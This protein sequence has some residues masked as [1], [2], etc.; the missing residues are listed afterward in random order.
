MAG[1]DRGAI[2]KRGKPA[3]APMMRPSNTPPADMRQPA[4]R[5]SPATSSA[6]KDFN[7]I[8][9]ARHP[10]ARPRVPF[11]IPRW[12]ARPDPAGPAPQI[13]AAD[14]CIRA[15]SFSGGGIPT[16]RKPIR[17]GHPRPPSSMMRPAGYV[18][19][20]RETCSVCAVAHVVTIRDPAT[21][22]ALHRGRFPRAAPPPTAA[23]ALLSFSCQ[24][25]RGS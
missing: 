1:A 12:A 19:T 13:P 2:R 16:D 21:C 6:G 14:A 20:S 24:K 7:F 18:G 9:S 4:A 15:V 25:K 11:G 22:H 8:L 5:H 17:P 10:C 23:G 3:H